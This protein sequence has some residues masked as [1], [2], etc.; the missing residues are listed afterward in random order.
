MTDFEIYSKE[1][2]PLLKKV[3]KICKANNYEF[4]SLTVF[5]SKSWHRECTRG[6]NL[7]IQANEENGPVPPQ[8]K[9]PSQ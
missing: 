9:T 7:I 8:M 5:D 1:I 6:G 4:A 3:F 2:S